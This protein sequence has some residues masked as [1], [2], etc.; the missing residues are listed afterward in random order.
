VAITVDPVTGRVWVANADSSSVSVFDGTTGALL[1]TFAVSGRP[2]ALAFAPDGSSVYVGGTGGIRRLDPAQVGLPRPIGDITPGLM[3]NAAAVAV[4]AAGRI[5]VADDDTG[6]VRIIDASSLG[7]FKKGQTDTPP[8]PA[9]IV[10]VGAAPRALVL[11]A[12]GSW[13]YVSLFDDDSVAVLDAVT[14]ALLTTVRVGAGPLGLNLT[15]DGQQLWVV[16]VFDATVSVV[17]TGTFAVSAPFA[18][19]NDAP[20]LS[21]TGRFLAVIADQPPQLVVDTTTLSLGAVNVARPVTRRVTITNGG[22][23]TLSWTATVSTADGGDWLS[24]SPAAGAGPAL[25]VTADPR[26]LEPGH[27]VGTVTVAADHG[28]GTQTIAVSFD[29]F[30]TRAFVTLQDTNEVAIV[31]PSDGTVLARVA[32]GEQ[33]FGVAVAPDGSRVYVTNAGS[34]TVSVI[35]PAT[36]TVVQTTPVGI[37]ASGIANSLFTS[38]IVTLVDN[39]SNSVVILPQDGPATT[40]PVGR[41]AYGIAVDASGTRGYVTNSLDDTLSIID[42]SN[43]TSVTVT[44]V[45][46]ARR[47]RGSRS[48][49]R[50]VPWWWPSRTTTRWRSSTRRRS[51][52]PG[53]AWAP[54]R[55][56]SR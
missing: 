42:R 31:D 34:G 2:R 5:Y 55:G 6:E 35:D 20:T 27:Y 47:P 19:G 33:P 46:V 30:P 28:E 9:I 18:V 11:D 45:P 10:P 40:V 48:T 12:S 37:G 25:D 38:W 29:V 17:N 52:S 22:H 1:D 50:A 32:V 36:A 14:G 21:V 49:R 15:P 7:G 8:G 51:R 41:G 13:L 26:G 54:D 53:C 56:A 23:G 24:V 16:N 44:A 4:S 43:P 39:N 3:T